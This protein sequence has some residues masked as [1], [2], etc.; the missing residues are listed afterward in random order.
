M[1]E[2]EDAISHEQKA[3]QELVDKV[4]KSIGEV[5]NP[6]EKVNQEM[7]Q[8]D[9][10]ITG[11]KH[12]RWNTDGPIAWKKAK[13]KQI[14]TKNESLKNIW[15]SIKDTDTTRAKDQKMNEIMAT[16]ESKGMIDAY[17]NFATTE[18]SKLTRSKEKAHAQEVKSYMSELN[19]CKA[20]PPL[21]KAVNKFMWEFTGAKAQI[22]NAWKMRG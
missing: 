21:R 1:H 5:K 22:R 10:V 7:G 18:L 9:L 8:V 2:F 12:K 13:A 19:G 6:H 17:K 4:N 16:V 20:C 15:I 11:L 3:K 14:N